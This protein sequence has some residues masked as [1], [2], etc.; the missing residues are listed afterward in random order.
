MDWMQ[1]SVRTSHE[2]MDL[3]ASVFDDIGANGVA[4]EDPAIIN[5]YINSK[6]WDYTD[7]PLQQNVEIVIVDAW[8]PKDE[9]LDGRIKALNVRLEKLSKTVNT[10]PCEMTYSDIKEEDWANNWKKYFHPVKIGEKVVVKPSWEK[11]EKTENELV[12]E[13]DPG[14]AFGTGTHPTTSMCVKFMEK[15]LQKDMKVFDVG[16]GSGILAVCAA[17][18]GVED[19]QAADYDNVAVKVASEN[20]RK[21][22]VS[23]KINCFQ[24]DLLQNFQGKADFISANIIA[25]IIIRLFDEI[26]GKLDKKG[27]LLASGI[28]E[29]RLPD[30]KTA[31]KK[32][33][34][35]IVDIKEKGGW[36][37][38][39]I[40]YREN[41]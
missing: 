23:D 29:E 12:I 30:I 34:M 39:I 32:H 31:A 25:D 4:M 18:L 22:N 37:A 16:T 6:L 24:S 7:I 40:K 2:A 8:L 10:A 19:I 36:A 3:I 38:L 13:L 15:Y 9:L 41:N 17:K 20:I 11:Y 33:N 35:H 5:D 14:C 28:I 21:N 1:I 26:S 27:I